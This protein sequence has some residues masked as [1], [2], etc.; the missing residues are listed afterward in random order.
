MLEFKFIL[1]LKLFPYYDLIHSSV[2]CYI[3]FRKLLI[4]YLKNTENFMI[5]IDIK[6]VLLE[7]KG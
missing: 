7:S 5:S 4:L 1:V 6:K 3:T 2:L